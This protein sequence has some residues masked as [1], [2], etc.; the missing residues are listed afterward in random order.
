MVINHN[1]T[2]EQIEYF[3][4]ALK[5]CGYSDEANIPSSDMVCDSLGMNCISLKVFIQN[6]CSF[7]YKNLPFSRNKSHAI[8]RVVFGFKFSTWSIHS[9]HALWQEFFPWQRLSPLFPAR[10]TDIDS[11]WYTFSRSRS[12]HC[13]YRIP[14]TLLARCFHYQ[15][16]E[17]ISLCNGRCC[18][19]NHFGLIQATGV[20]YI[21][22][23]RLHH[24]PGR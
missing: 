17:N 23:I 12:I 13:S 24:I 3:Y 11:S 4:N 1:T 10:F 14:K 8:R 2:L 9:N 7:Y 15:P 18:D 6:Q 21:L 16:T 20:G 5:S 22:P 19:S